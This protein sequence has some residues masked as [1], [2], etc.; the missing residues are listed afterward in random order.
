MAQAVDS[1]LPAD[2]LYWS[3]FDDRNPIYLGGLEPGHLM[4]PAHK[5]KC[6]R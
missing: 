4:T 2:R 3:E 5:R 1:N 6:N